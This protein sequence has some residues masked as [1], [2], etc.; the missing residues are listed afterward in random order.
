[1]SY[2][3]GLLEDSHQIIA[4]Y[5]NPNIAP[6][7]EYDKRLTE[8]KR[9]SEMKEFPLFIGSFDAG[10]WTERVKRYRF[11]GEKSERCWECYRM[12]LEE[13]FKKAGELGVDAVT[14][15]LSVS[16]H[17][18]AAVINHI[19]KELEKFSGIEFLDADFKKGNGYK[20]S[21][22]LS[23]MYGFYRQNYCGCIY[24]KIERQKRN[25]AAL[26]TNC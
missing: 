18:D 25:P 4:F 14:T 5:Y 19:G 21:V 17:K 6:Q 20:K 24:S 16:P 11:C 8:L 12:R 2:V 10:E 26:K 1:M 23:R 22:E 3:H 9:F 13:A 7:S 15:S